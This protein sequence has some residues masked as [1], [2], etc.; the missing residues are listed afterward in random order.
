MKK[1]TILTLACICLIVILAATGCRPAERPVPETDPRMDQRVPGDPAID[2][3]APGGT[4]DAPIPPVAP[5]P[6]GGTVPEEPMPEERLPG[7]P[8]APERQ[9]GQ[10]VTPTR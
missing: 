3:A 2:P 1:K 7:Q 10:V 5:V 6:G 9:R 8:A 4:P